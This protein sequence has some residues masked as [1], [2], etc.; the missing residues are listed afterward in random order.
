MIFGCSHGQHLCIRAVLSIAPSHV[1]TKLAHPPGGPVAVPCQ[2]SDCTSGCMCL[3]GGIYLSDPY[4]VCPPGEH[5]LLGQ[6][7]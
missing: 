1:A 3:Q 7:H 4:C 2:T 6:V 5:M